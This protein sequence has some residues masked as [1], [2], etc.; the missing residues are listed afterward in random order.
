MAH[1]LVVDND[2]IAAERA[3]QLLIDAGHACG[4]VSDAETAMKVINR[5]R[6]DLILL[7]ENLPG[8]C[9]TSFLRRLRNSPRFYDLPVIMLTTSMGFKEEQIAYY[10]GAQDYIRKPFGERSLVFRVKKLVDARRQRPAHQP[11]AERVGVAAAKA[12]APL[13]RI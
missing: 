11:L 3:A 12:P 10:N 7:D 6:P 5:R 8:E 13:R 9:G 1:I 4:W 2:D